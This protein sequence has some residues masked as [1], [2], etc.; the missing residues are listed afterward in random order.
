MPKIHKGRPP[1]YEADILSADEA[2]ALV[3]ALDEQVRA[4]LQHAFDEE[5]KLVTGPP[6]RPTPRKRETRAQAGVAR[7]SGSAKSP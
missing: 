1:T 6:P 5:E 3:E 2:S 7:G 4:D